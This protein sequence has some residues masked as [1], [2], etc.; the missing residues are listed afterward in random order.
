LQTEASRD[1]WKKLYEAYSE[2]GMGTYFTSD[3]EA[4]V[5]EAIA[6]LQKA[7]EWEE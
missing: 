2:Y 6:A 4:E 1:R 5:K 3:G 7:G